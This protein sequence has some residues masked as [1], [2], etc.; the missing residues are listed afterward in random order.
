MR[1][2]LLSSTLFVLI[3]LGCNKPEKS[4][5]FEKSQ[6]QI[7]NQDAIKTNDLEIVSVKQKDLEKELEK[8]KATFLL[9]KN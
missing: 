4:K 6:T 2:I 8:P 7:T 1:D 3:I 9:V 5:I